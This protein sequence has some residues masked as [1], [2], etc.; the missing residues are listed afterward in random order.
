MAEKAVRRHHTGHVVDN[1]LHAARDEDYNAKAAP[2]DWDVV[3]Y[4]CGLHR[5]RFLVA[6]IPTREQPLPSV[7]FP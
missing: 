1:L 4:D 5:E 7:G 2:L 6:V 3:S